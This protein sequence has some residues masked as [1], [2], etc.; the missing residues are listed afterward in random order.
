MSVEILTSDQRW[1]LA[2]AFVGF[3]IV[4]VLLRWKTRRDGFV[5]AA[6]MAASMAVGTPTRVITA[7][8]PIMPTGM[9]IW[10]GLEPPPILGINAM[11]PA[12]SAP[13]NPARIQ[14]VS[15]A[16]DPGCSMFSMAV[17]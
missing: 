15:R 7:P 3:G 16:S 2:A 6:T 4:A 12:V 9:T 10:T 11:P 14:P 1:M 13:P 17:R 5:V 8:T